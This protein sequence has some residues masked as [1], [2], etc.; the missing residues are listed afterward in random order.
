MSVHRRTVRDGVVYDV[1]LRDVDGRAYKRT[2]RTR[3]EADTFEAQQKAERSTGSW[4]DPRA[5]QVSLRD[6]ST[7]W[8]ADRPTLRPRTRELYEG[9]LRLH[10]LPALGHVNLSDLTPE[11]IRRWHADLIRAGHPGPPT[12]AKCYRLLRTILNTALDDGLIAKNP[13]RIKQAG[14]ER[15]PER[16]VATVEQVLAL[17]DAMSGKYR[18]LVLLA[19]FAGLRVGE[20]LGLTRSSLDLDAGTVTIVRQLQELAG[21][22]FHTAPPKTHAGR[23]TIALPAFV[24]PQLRQHLESYAGPGPDGLLFL[25][26][27]G[28]PLRRAVLWR[29]WQAAIA[30]V[31]MKG[32]HVHDLRHTGN[33]LA[34]AT[35]ASTKELMARMGHAS[36]EAALRYQHATARRDAAIADALDQMVGGRTPAGSDAGGRSASDTGA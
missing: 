7:R 11:R 28:G 12:V 30:Q 18:A 35:G 15:S 26:E 19:T 32:F 9:E 3:K 4:I 24:V 36:A 27:E 29:H 34:A 23:R 14:I 8:L 5:G 10:I 31:G 22:E 17:C 16:P 25:G 2:F 1:R 33:T 6:Y 20:I 21:G 13:C